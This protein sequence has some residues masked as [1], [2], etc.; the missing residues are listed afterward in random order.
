MSRPYC[1]ECQTPLKTL[2][3]E[4]NFKI[5]IM[6]MNHLIKHSRAFVKMNKEENENKSLKLENQ[7]LREKL[8]KY[9]DN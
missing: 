2:F 4:I 6:F 1:K 8:K 9:E 7:Y 5:V 3:Q